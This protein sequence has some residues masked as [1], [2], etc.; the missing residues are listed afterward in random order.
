[1]DSSLQFLFISFTISFL[2]TLAV[3]QEEP[4]DYSCME[5]G[6]NFTIN[7]TYETNLNRLIS[8]FSANTANDY[9]FY[10]LSSGE[11]SNRVNSTALCRGDV[12]S[13]DCLGCINNATT[14]LRSLC[15]D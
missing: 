6:V 12:G 2:L 11:G 1:M 15:P 10:N 8:S 7:S 3:A 13:G 14:E 9:G 4:L 5:T